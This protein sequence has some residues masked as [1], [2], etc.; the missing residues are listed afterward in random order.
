[1]TDQ[2]L[3]QNTLTGWVFGCSHVIWKILV[4]LQ[5][6]YFKYS[7]SNCLYS[8][9]VAAIVRECNCIPMYSSREWR[10]IYSRLDFIPQ[11]FLNLNVSFFVEGSL[12][13]HEVSPKKQPL[14]YRSSPLPS[15]RIRRDENILETRPY[16]MGDQLRCME[17]VLPLET[18]TGQI[19]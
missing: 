14:T 15:L 4:V 19:C 11:N 10:G 3:I 7:M 16:C 2:S 17:V 5:E 6:R 8:A 9:M 12:L 18:F 13:G 1:M